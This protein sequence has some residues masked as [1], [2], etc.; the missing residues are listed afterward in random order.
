MLAR[1]APP[2]YAAGC[3][4]VVVGFVEIAAAEVRLIVV[5]A[6]KGVVIDVDIEGH[7]V[8]VTVFKTVT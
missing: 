3:V 1:L 6:G 8:A 2:V 5:A 7:I 4:F